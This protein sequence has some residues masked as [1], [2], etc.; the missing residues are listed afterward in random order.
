MAFS[1]L[2]RKHLCSSTCV[3]TEKFNTHKILPSLEQPWAL[4]GSSVQWTKGKGGLSLQSSFDYLEQG[5]T[6]LSSSESGGI[7]CEDSG[8]GRNAEFFLKKC[9][10]LHVGGAEPKESA[11]HALYP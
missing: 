4:F 2:L 6:Q 11:L 9:P 3:M 7:H 1:L 8:N 5:P 10:Y